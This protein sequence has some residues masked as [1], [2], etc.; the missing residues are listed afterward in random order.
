[1]EDG[2]FYPNVSNIDG[3]E[4]FE[5]LLRGDV[6]VSPIGRDV[7]LRSADGRKHLVFVAGGWCRGQKSLPGAARRW[8]A[9]A[10]VGAACLGV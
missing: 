2:Q 9:P 5:R 6:G 3:R 1:M 7:I 10:F 8:A 4:Q